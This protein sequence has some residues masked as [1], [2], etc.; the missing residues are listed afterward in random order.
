MNK[1]NPH[2]VNYW[3]E[4]KGETTIINEKGFITYKIF[5]N[6]QVGEKEIMIC[7]FYVAREHRGG[8]AAKKLADEVA[9]VGRKEGCTHLS[10]YIQHYGDSETARIRTSYKLHVYLRYGMLVHSMTET[11][12]LMYKPL[13][14]DDGGVRKWQQQYL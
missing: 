3:L 6:A 4:E 1:L 11:Y 2:F 14:E 9:E 10:C 13:N 12:I 5:D 8:F 7:E